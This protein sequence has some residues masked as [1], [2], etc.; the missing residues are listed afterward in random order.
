MEGSGFVFDHADRLHYKSHTI[1]LRRCGSYID[2]PEWIKSKKATTNKQ[3]NDKNCFKYV[4]I[5]AL[6][7]ENIGKNPQKKSKIRPFIHQ[8]DESIDQYDWNEIHFQPEAK[9]W[10]KCEANNILIALN[11]C[12]NH[13]IKK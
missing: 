12:S 2:S 8:Y 6:N 1:S 7:H 10:K 11:V 9:D 4:V 13:T 3:N 5:V